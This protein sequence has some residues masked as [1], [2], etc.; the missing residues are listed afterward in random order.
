ME[1]WNVAVRRVLINIRM[2][3]M[4]WMGFKVI[5]LHILCYRMMNSKKHVKK[6]KQ[7]EKTEKKDKTFFYG[8]IYKNIGIIYQN[9]D[10]LSMISAGFSIPLRSSEKPAIDF[11]FFSFGHHS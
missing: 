6:K 5:S 8:K 10:S 3:I 9:I 4:K 11:P 7:V 1:K 2:G